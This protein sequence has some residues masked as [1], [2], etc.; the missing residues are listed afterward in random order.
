MS[1]AR[2]PRPVYRATN[3]PRGSRSLLIAIA[4]LAVVA[5]MLPLAPAAFAAGNQA[6]QIDGVDAHGILLGTNGSARGHA[7]HAGAVVQA[8]G[9]RRRRASTGSGGNTDSIPLIT[10]GRSES[11]GGN[12]DTNYFFGIDASSGELEA[13]FEDT[14]SGANHP[15]NGVTPSPR[16][17][18]TTP[19][20]RSTDRSS[21]STSTACS[22]GPCTATT[23]IPR[24]DSIQGRRSGPLRTH[25][26]RSSG[27]R[28]LVQ[29]DEARI[30]NV[31]H[32]QAADPGDHELR[33]DLRHRAPR[34]MG[35]E[36][37]LR[38]PRRPVRS[39]GINGTLTT[40]TA[41]SPVLPRSTRHRLP[42]GNN[43]R[44]ARRG[45]R[46]HPPG[47]GP[48]RLGV[49]NSPW[50]CGSSRRPAGVA[51]S[52]GSGGNLDSIPLITKGRSESDGSNVDTNY[53][54]GIDARAVRARGGLRGH[55]DGGPTTRSTERPRSPRTSG[56]TPPR[57]ST[58]SQ[59]CVYLDGVLD[60]T[61]SAT[62]NTPAIRLHP[63]PRD[64]NCLRT[65]SGAHAA[66]SR[67]V[68]RAGRRGRGSGASPGT[69]AQIQASMNPESPLAPDLLGRWG[70]ERRPGTTTV[71]RLVGRLNGTAHGRHDAGSPVHPRCGH[72]RTDRRRFRHHPA[73]DR[74]SHV[75]LGAPGSAALG[76]TNYTLELWFKRTGTG[77]ATRR[78][79]CTGPDVG[80]PADH[81]GPIVKRRRERSTSTTSWASTGHEPL[82]HRLR[83]RRE[84]QPRGHE[85]RVRGAIPPCP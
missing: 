21:A 80:H 49:T 1:L 52:T 59:L 34:S 46:R 26:R 67:P 81:E 55:G 14:A 22:T 2:S 16:T 64:R 71:D 75:D 79:Q 28:S 23:T 66:A 13:D 50:S 76:A 65:R 15:V 85:P 10:K 84:R 18:G 39:V 20:R 70:D 30:W 77:V 27:A 32:S 74:G 12:I 62:T 54:F 73:G 45:R 4:T 31:A 19:P 63:E 8:D 9:R 72:P 58:A 33:G 35:N 40:G 69:Q 37:R 43:G 38:A 61:C 3:R 56:T 82:G 47:D 7:V 17:C 78:A 41:G 42:S 68:R 25:R 44:P 53:F 5:S 60:G 29:V 11:D 83:G 24:S 6:V 57:R 36:R 48:L 51:A